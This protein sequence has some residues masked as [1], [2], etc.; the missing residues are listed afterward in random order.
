MAILKKIV[1]KIKGWKTVIFSVLLGILGVVETARWAD[2]LPKEK[3]G[4][5]LIVIGI[6]GVILRAFTTGSIGQK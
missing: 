5:I 2:I 1:K 6:I 3:V 4:I